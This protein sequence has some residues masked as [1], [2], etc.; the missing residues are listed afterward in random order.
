MMQLGAWE[1]KHF[2]Q[3]LE[4]EIILLSDRKMGKIKFLVAKPQ[5]FPI[6]KILAIEAL[7]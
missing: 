4:T 5:N 3:I 2:R 1:F 6:L 7:D